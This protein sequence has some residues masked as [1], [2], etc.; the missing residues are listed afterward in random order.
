MVVFLIIGNSSGV[1]RGTTLP[2][3]TQGHTNIIPSTQINPTEIN[4]DTNG[5]HSPKGQDNELFKIGDWTL[6]RKWFIT[7]VALGSVILSA[8][9]FAF[10]FMCIRKRHRSGSNGRL[11]RTQVQNRDRNELLQSSGSYSKTTS[12]YANISD[13]GYVKVPQNSTYEKV[14]PSSS[15]NGSPCNTVLR[16]E[17]SPPQV[18][19]YVEP[20]STC[21]STSP[22]KSFNLFAERRSECYPETGESPPQFAEYIFVSK[23]GPVYKKPSNVP[24]HEPPKERPPTK[25]ESE[26]DSYVCMQ[27]HEYDAP[28]SPY[29]TAVFVPDESNQMYETT[30]WHSNDRNDL[31]ETAVFVP[32]DP[33][34]PDYVNGSMARP[35]R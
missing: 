30:G 13:N 10:I 5:K 25:E 18:R 35:V 15:V 26:R 28:T 4:V 17:G 16:A 24:K 27:P 12:L 9:L 1:E 7:G 11:V 34:E 2:P 20:A 23:D 8:T 19:V 6:D 29:E 3:Y 31:Y 32:P 33:D 14:S 21:V 22:S